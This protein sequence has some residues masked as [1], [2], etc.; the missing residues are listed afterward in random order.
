MS[1]KAFEPRVLGFL[2]N[3]CCYAAAD[4]AGVARY[5]Y[6]PNI[7]VIRV[8]CSGRI[9]PSFPLEGL[10]AGADGVFI[11][12]CH[13]GDCHYQ[14][15]N[16]EAMGVIRLVWLLLDA[17]GVNRAR[18]TLEWASAAE[19]PQFVQHVTGFTR[20]L[21]PLGPLGSSEGLS[22]A[23]LRVKLTAAR[24]AAKGRKLRMSF[25]N[26]AKKLRAEQ[27]MRAEDIEARV[28]EALAGLVKE[29]VAQAEMLLRLAAGPA[30]AAELAA[31]VGL[32]AAVAEERLAALAK[33][34]RLAQEGSRWRLAEPAAEEAPAKAAAAPAAS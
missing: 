5:Q 30:T 14:S 1:A 26:L 15:G 8:M 24:D 3:W 32:E 31:K 13:L 25:G 21:I 23:D 7:R 29:E 2:C 12:G 6:P 22:A 9:D 20:S 18:V 34:G 33:R 11:G 10:L 17:A 4:A 16:Y 19:A 28:R 27:V